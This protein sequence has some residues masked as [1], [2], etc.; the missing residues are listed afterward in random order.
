MFGGAAQRIVIDH[1][2]SNTGFGSVDFI[3]ASA[4]CTAALVL[5]IVDELG[6]ELTE[7]IATCIYAGLVTDTG[8]FKWARPR[9][10]PSPHGC[11]RRGRRREM[12]SAA[13]R[14]AMHSRGSASPAP[15]WRRPSWS[16]LRSTARA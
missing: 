7:P 4:D 10:S 13:A 3:D 15:S 12:E 9:R 11:L 5:Q 2:V 8:S 6:V 16:P 14:T 1:H